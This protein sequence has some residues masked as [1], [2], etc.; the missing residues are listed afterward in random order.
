MRF[1]PAAACRGAWLMWSTYLARFKV[2]REYSAAHHTKPES[3]V[4]LDAR[5]PVSAKGWWVRLA[6]VLVG[7]LALWLAFKQY[8][9]IRLEDALITFRYAE[10][11]ASGRGFAYNPGEAVLGTTTPLLTLILAAVGRMFGIAAV[12]M[13]ADCLLTAASLGTAALVA[14]LILRA[15]RNPEAA[16]VAAAL[17]CAHPTT[18]WITMGGMETPLVLLLM[19]SSL[20]AGWMG[21][22]TLA[23]C[24]LALLVITRIDGALWA[25]V[26]FIMAWA[27]EDR[28]RLVWPTILGVGVV[29]A[30]MVCATLYFGS[31]VPQSVLAKRALG[32]AAGLRA[33]VR[34]DLHALSFIERP[35]WIWLVGVAIESAAILA[36]GPKSLLSPFVL[37]P[38]VLG[39][40]YWLGGAPLE[41][42]WY[43]VPVTLCGLV[44]GVC[45]VDRVMRAWSAR[46]KGEGARIT[47]IAVAT[48]TI[49]LL[50]ADLAL[51]D[52]RQ[53]VIDRAVQE[54]ENGLRRTV[55]EWLAR[56]TPPGATVAM[57]AIGYQGTYS[58]RRVVDLAGLIS[59]EVVALYKSAPGHAAAFENVL[60]TLR[61]DYLVLRSFEVDT[62]RH[63][64]GGVLFETEGQRMTFGRL[65]QEVRRF[66]APHPEV[67]G[68]LSHLTVYARK[69]GT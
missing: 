22:W 61:P 35:W 20:Y 45:G 16:L 23:A 1:A 47:L 49:A 39:I 44:L 15:S 19:T 56:A 60:L 57:E 37:Y 2:L 28:R 43:A 48:L 42:P 7:G 10:N 34:W 6:G 12:P 13:A 62:N 64:H 52:Y 59:P 31:P 3:R 27:R 18:L 24:L 66:S 63:Y 30:W 29:T 41:F 36:S 14:L 68:P 40:A 53:F 8:T 5:A 67:W 46:V 26:L 11:L 32:E 38:P 65:Y 55:G 69:P 54:N 50:A 9:G 17:F 4:R 51:R 58:K 21:R 25:G 33:Y